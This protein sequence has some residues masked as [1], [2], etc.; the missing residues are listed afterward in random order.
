MVASRAVDRMECYKIQYRQT[1]TEG[2]AFKA[3]CPKPC[4]SKAS[5]EK[6]CIFA[7]LGKITFS[8]FF[9]QNITSS[10]WLPATPKARA[11]RAGLGSVTGGHSTRDKDSHRSDQKKMKSPRAAWHPEP[12]LGTDSLAEA[13]MAIQLLHEVFERD[14]SPSRLEDCEAGLV[15][16]KQW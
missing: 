4:D 10:P 5:A 3:V 2:G 9:P 1:C 16:Q 15:P 13:R 8:D 11:Y 12:M 14:P 6:R 7:T